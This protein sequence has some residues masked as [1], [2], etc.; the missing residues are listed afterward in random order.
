MFVL[1]IYNL[2]Y[3]SFIYICFLYIALQFVNSIS[4]SC[5][6]FYHHR[7]WFDPFAPILQDAHVSFALLLWPFL[8][9]SATCPLVLN[10]ITLST[11]ALVL[12]VINFST[13]P[14]VLT[15]ITLSF[16][17]VGNCRR[18]SLLYKWNVS[19]YLVFYC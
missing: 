11:S 18:F 12:T 13:C 16:T 1:N 2:S 10:V 9:T 3:L 5:C 19:S 7:P 4:F 6:Y 17:P 15:V 14:L 8:W